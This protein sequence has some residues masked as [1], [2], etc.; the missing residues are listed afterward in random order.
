MTNLRLTLSLP[1][2]DGDFCCCGPELLELPLLRRVLASLTTRLKGINC[3]STLQAKNKQ[4][5]AT[6]NRL[7]L[8][9]LCT[10]KKRWK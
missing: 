8:L 1:I 3:S 10:A 5:C 9:K 2:C 4:A 7:C 6:I